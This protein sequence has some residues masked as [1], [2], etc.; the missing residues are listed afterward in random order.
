MGNTVQIRRE[1]RTDGSQVG[2]YD[3][4]V[5]L[6]PLLVLCRGHLGASMII[7]WL[8]TPRAREAIT[9][10]RFLSPDTL[11]SISVSAPYVVFQI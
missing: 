9:G 7:A 10:R 3:D 11:F 1:D 5:R 8:K 2:V 6:A 4:V